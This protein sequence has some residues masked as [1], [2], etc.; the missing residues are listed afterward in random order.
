MRGRPCY[1]PRSES[2]P[3]RPQLR[4]SSRSAPPSH[5]PRS[6]Y[7]GTVAAG[8]SSARRAA[9]MSYFGRAPTSRRWGD[10]ALLCTTLFTAAPTPEEPAAEAPG[11]VTWGRM[12]HRYFVTPHKRARPGP[13]PAWANLFPR[14]FTAVSVVS[15]R[16]VSS[17]SCARPSPAHAHC[18]R[19]SGRRARGP[20]APRPSR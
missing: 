3:A 6:S 2:L 1:L 20:R 15:F 9:L 14:H 11:C 12:E 19:K 17:E 16:V 4:R 10:L 13:R 5:P 8:R 7:T 18:I